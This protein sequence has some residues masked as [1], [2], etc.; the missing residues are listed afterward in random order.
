MDRQG[1]V[2][3][4]V[5]Y[6]ECDPQGVAHHASYAPWLEIGRTE[7]LR[8]RGLSYA[9]LER[10]GVLIVVTRLEIVYRRPV[11]Y[12]DLLE[13]RTRG[14]VS[15]PV[16]LRHAYQIALV[17]RSG[18]S[19]TDCQDPTVPID[20]VCARASTELA[21]LASDGRPTRV[22]Q[23]LFEALGITLGA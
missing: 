10:R 1:I 12:D 11:R 13:I 8:G 21:V 7:L 6:N 15:T 19:A 17:E 14:E 20:G 22:P 23:E 9:S 3:L 2:R 5:R 18:V 16:R 4:R